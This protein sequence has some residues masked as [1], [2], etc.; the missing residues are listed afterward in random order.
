MALEP[1]GE[2]DRIRVSDREREQVVE[3]LGAATAEGRLTLDE[4]AD[5]ATAAHAA[6]TRGE[7]ARLTEDLPSHP[8]SD[9]VARPATPLAPTGPAPERLLAIFGEDSRKGHWLVPER[10][11]ARSIF[12]GIEIELQDA[13]LQHP[14]TT[15]EV[16]AVF[17]A[18]TVYV[19]EGVEVRI[20]GTAILGTK[21][22]KL[23]GAPPAPGSPRVEVHCRVIF[24]SLTVR[25][26]K[27]RWW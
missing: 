25:R 12:G 26:P 7:L 22:S 23:R 15:I 17:G 27:R 10:L 2:P 11:E 14:V 6:M 9:A 5:R 18:V 16:T 4:Y 24:G 20:L 8:P 19:P 13:Q 3:L 1:Q 21:E